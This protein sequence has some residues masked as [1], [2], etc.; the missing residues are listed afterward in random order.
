MSEKRFCLVQDDSSHWYCI[1]L[2][3]RAT[4][5]ELGEGL[6]SDDDAAW[7]EWNELGFDAMR[8]NMYVSNYSFTDWQEERP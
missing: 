7:A 3:L 4:F 2:E 8:L 6:E 5:E 1:P